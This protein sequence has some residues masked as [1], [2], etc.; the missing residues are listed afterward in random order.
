MEK[1]FPRY[2]RNLVDS[3]LKDR[4][5]EYPIR[6]GGRGSRPVRTG[7]P[8]GSVLGPLLWNI[9]YDAILQERVERCRVVCYADDTLILASANEIVTAVCRANL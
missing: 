1:R 2:L 8:Q 3:Y 4:W 9:A 7:V 6:S 5:V